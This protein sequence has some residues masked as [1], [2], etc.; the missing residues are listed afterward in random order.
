MEPDYG[1]EEC[2]DDYVVLDKV[3][4]RDE[5]GSEMDMEIPDAELYERGQGV[6]SFMFGRFFKGQSAVLH[7]IICLNEE[8]NTGLAR[9]SVQKAKGSIGDFDKH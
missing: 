7:Y 2:P 5:S 3:I 4:L 6:Q 1:C 9:W 8:K